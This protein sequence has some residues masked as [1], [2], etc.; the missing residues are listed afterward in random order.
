MDGRQV[1]S[2]ISST[3][4]NAWMESERAGWV[5]AGTLRTLTARGRAGTP[6]VETLD[7]EKLLGFASNDYLGLAGDPRVIESAIEAIRAYGWGAGA[8]PLVTGWTALHERLT[9]EIA[10]FEGAQAVALF[11]SGYAANLGAMAVL[12]S[13]GDVVVLDRLAHG[14]LVAGARLSG[15]RI[16]V[17]PHNDANRL[18]AILGRE[19]GQARRLI[20]ATESLFSMD[21]DL[22]PLGEIVEICQRRGAMLVVDEA[23]ATGVMGRSG[24][25]MIA[26]LGL[27]DRVTLRVGTLSKALGSI[28]GFV[29]GDRRVVERIGQVAGSFRYSTSLPPAAAA[30][31]LAA[32]EIVREEPSR[33]GRLHDHVR[34]L[35]GALSQRNLV[36]RLPAG[37]IMPI[38]V[39]DSHAALGLAESLRGRGLLIPAIRPPTVPIGSAR[40]R[41][42]VSAAHERIHLERLVEAL[43]A[44]RPHLDRE[45]T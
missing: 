15:A 20:V 38:V 14:S 16:R 12:A 2:G 1:S 7:G 6:W 32:L 3:D 40:L 26:D 43:D 28:G 27:G 36:E 10:E 29:A 22:A 19:R 21:G 23:H 25:G 5:E 37:P 9:C 17:F 45:R 24:G 34:W 30:A 4:A 18:D 8:A 39:G 42:S 44:A 13:A 33:R 41:V 35:A 31:A 11:S